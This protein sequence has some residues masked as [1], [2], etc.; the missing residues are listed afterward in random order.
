MPYCPKCDMEFIEGITVC[1]DCGGPLAES[2][3][4]WEKQFLQNTP[5]PAEDPEDF[6]PFPEEEALTPEE[7]TAARET[8]RKASGAPALS[9]VFV[10][11]RQRAEELHSSRSAFLLVGTIG[12]LA[13]ALFWTGIIRLPMAGGSRL[14]FQDVVTAISLGCL[15]VALK[16]GHSIRQTEERAA[17]EEARTAEIIQWFLSQWDKDTLDRTLQ[18]EE[19]ALDSAELDLRRYALI[20]DYLITGQDL[21]E[22]AYADYLAEEIYT[23]LYA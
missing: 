12:A 14:L 8:S 15:L 17:A 3:E 22:P 6:F 18:A 7:S 2:K 10:P 5:A 19:T 11:A 16:T 20:Q 23:R 4:S 1:S 21:P 13:S 9:S